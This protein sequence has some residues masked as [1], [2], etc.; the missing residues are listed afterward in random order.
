[1]II[2][3]IGN[4]FFNPLGSLYKHTYK[5]RISEKK[6][7]AIIEKKIQNKPGKLKFLRIH[8]SPKY[9]FVRG[10]ATVN[11]KYFKNFLHI[12]DADFAFKLRMKHINGQ[13]IG[14]SVDDFIIK[15][16]NK[17][18]IDWLNIFSKWTKRVRNKVLD[19]FNKSNAPFF[20]DLSRETLYLD[21]NYF[22]KD[23][24]DIM[25]NTAIEGVFFERNYL[26]IIGKSNVLTM[27]TIGVFSTDL[28]EIEAVNN[29]SLD[30]FSSIWNILR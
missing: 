19:E 6:I 14:F 9:G 12:K 5:I 18:K 21:L 16:R 26:N 15:E 17:R 24:P 28:L 13:Y 3:E 7:N 10:K 11:K 27:T 4:V 25:G 30:V 1:M 8:I 29:Q 20:S 23:V 2:P 22:L